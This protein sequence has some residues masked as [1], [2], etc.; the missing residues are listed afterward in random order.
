MSS[1]KNTESKLQKSR[2]KA[3]KYLWH[4]HPSW[5]ERFDH[6]HWWKKFKATQDGAMWEVLRRHP[7]TEK[8][9][10][11]DP[12]LSTNL[13]E[14]ERLLM[15][16][17]DRSWPEATKTDI[18]FGKYWGKS[19]HALPPEWGIVKQGMFDVDQ[20]Q[21]QKLQELGRR[22]NAS[23]QRYQT[24]QK[25]DHG[26]LKCA[27]QIWN[28]THKTDKM[29]VPVLNSNSSAFN[30]L[31][32]GCVLVGFDPRKPG[33]AEIVEK[34]VRAIINEVKQSNAIGNTS[35]KSYWEAWLDVIA[36]FEDAELSRLR[37][38]KNQIRN[39][40]LFARYRRSYKNR[41]WPF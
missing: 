37:S 8:L 10:C 9:L 38:K 34:R 24:P 12:S 2:R 11:R 27:Y 35:R 33:I 30:A 6:E 1:K 13:L 36:Q 29:L 7:Q 25:I 40:Q 15:Y 22:Y 3:A 41:P 4:L 16:K 19:L 23:L 18:K 5:L 26:A 32:S 20:I 17:G 39:D 31:F 28:A 21:D 14:F